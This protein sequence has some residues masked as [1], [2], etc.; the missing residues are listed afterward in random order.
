MTSSAEIA[1]N[2]IRALASY[3]ADGALS[4]DNAIALIVAII[5]ILELD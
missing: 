4:D 3:N 2:T 5:N 1:I